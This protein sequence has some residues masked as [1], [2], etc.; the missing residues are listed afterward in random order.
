M[1][2]DALFIERLL[3]DYKNRGYFPSAVCAVFTRDGTLF[4]V[5]VG[6]VKENTWFDLASVS[7][8]VCATMALHLMEE[9]RLSPETPVLSVLPLDLPGAAT[10][11]RLSRVTVRMLMTHTSGIVPWF[12]FYCDGRGFFAVLERV[13]SETP[14]QQGM[15][16][17]DIN[18]MLLGL[19]VCHLTGRTLRE[20]LDVYIRQPLGIHTM[21]YGP[22]DPA[23]CAPS[24]YGNQIEQA[25]CAQ[26]GLSFD[27]WR[28]NGV[29]VAGSCNDGN[30]HYYWQGVSGHAGVFADAAALTALCR[31]YMNTGRPRFIQA[32]EETVHNRGL[33]FDKSDAFPEGC[34]HSGFTGTSIWFSRER[35]IGAVILTNKYFRRDGAA[36]GNT[37]DVRRA[38]HY[39]LLGREAPV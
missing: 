4:T 22:V 25:M 38:V 33:G 31:Y 1:H 39:A 10:R 26:R 2:A 19:I 5:C 9:G 29:A 21:A 35:N 11:K 16:Y 27:G 6:D 30:A 37:N 32:M 12:P 20:N 14:A 3:M 36:P 28:E 15:A 23:L 34:G 13:L 17:S 8:V 24:C 18:F 7:K